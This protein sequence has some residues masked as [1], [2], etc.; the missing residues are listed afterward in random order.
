[1]AIVSIKELVEAG[2]HFGH[3]ASRWN[4]KMKPYVFDKRNLIHIINLKE[5]I[6]GLIRSTRFLAK[7]ASR[8]EDVLFVGTKRQARVN[9]EAQARRCGMPY[10]TERWL[11]GTLTNF[12]TI[13]SRVRRLEE[14]EE[15][16]TSGRI[17][18]YSKK[19]IATLTREKEKIRRNLEGIRNMKR[20]PGALIVVDPHHEKNA[21]AEARGLGIPVIALT[22]T[23]SDPDLVD[24]VTPGNDDAIRSILLYVR[25]MADAVIEGKKDAPKP[26]KEEAPSK[27]TRGKRAPATKTERERQPRRGGGRREGA[28][29][30]TQRLP[31]GKTV[32]FEK[33]AQRRGGGRRGTSRRPERTEESAPAAEKPEAAAVGT[34]PEE[35]EAPKPVEQTPAEVPKPETKPVEQAPAQTPAPVTDA[36]KSET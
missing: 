22:D 12:R 9:V 19:M 21:V 14:L 3:R 6:K 8:G 25:R 18:L 34:K 32:T 30:T 15:L 36:E 29:T 5:T 33:P 17:Q 10:V 28:R 24:M 16:E 27:R 35:A 7:V 13:T 31:G 26:A 1:L 20:L 11:G 23:D 2:V 4:P